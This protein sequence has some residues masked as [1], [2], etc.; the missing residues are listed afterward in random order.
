VL[1][2]K[3]QFPK[4]GNFSCILAQSGPPVK[5]SGNGETEKTQRLSKKKEKGTNAERKTALISAGG[6]SFSNGGNH[7]GTN[8]DLDR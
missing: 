8:P 6:I 4:K 7:H 3:R 2:P 5:K 1:Y